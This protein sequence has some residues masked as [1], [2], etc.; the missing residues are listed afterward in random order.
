MAPQVLSVNV[1]SICAHGVAGT[2]HGE[3]RNTRPLEME[4]M[5]SLTIFLVRTSILEMP[6]FKFGIVPYCS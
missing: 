6:S 5:P 1:G 2:H 3:W 4:S